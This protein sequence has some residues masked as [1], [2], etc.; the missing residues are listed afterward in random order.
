MIVYTFSEAHSGAA[1]GAK[2]RAAVDR[3][4]AAAFVAQTGSEGYTGAGSAY[5]SHH[6]RDVPVEAVDPV[7]QVQGV[8]PQVGFV[9]RPREPLY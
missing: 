7:L 3:D 2:T 8:P 6:R 9:T 1:Q 5:E 4:V